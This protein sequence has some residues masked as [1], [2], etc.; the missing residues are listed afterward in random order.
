MEVVESMT[1]CGDPRARQRRFIKIQR[2]EFLT[3]PSFL[4]E[5]TAG[6]LGGATPDCAVHFFIGRQGAGR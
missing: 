6:G 2:A 4:R 1:V 5:G 3:G